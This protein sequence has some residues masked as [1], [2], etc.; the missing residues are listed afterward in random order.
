[1]GTVLAPRNAG[2]LSALGALVGGPRRERSRTVLLDARDRAGRERVWRAL[3][4]E[5]RAAF[6]VSE[7]GRVRVERWA[8]MRYAGQSHELSVTDDKDLVARFHHEHRRRFGFSRARHAVEIVTVEVRASLAGQRLASTQGGHSPARPSERSRVRE[9]GRW[10]S[11]PVWPRETLGAGSVAK[12]PAL[13]VESG[14]T[15]WIPGG[16]RARGG[17]AGTL[18]ITRERS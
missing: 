15:L 14:A 4:K 5:V 6:A 8:E 1:V 13:V 3:E 12:G 7:R 9:A 18:V 11:A 2:V 16:W 10:I 17:A